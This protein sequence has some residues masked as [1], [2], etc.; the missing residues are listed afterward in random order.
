M[1][2]GVFLLLVGVFCLAAAAALEAQIREIPQR[3]V[4]RSKPPGT[5]D[6]LNED[7]LRWV[8]RQLRLDK[9]Q[10]QQA[11][12]L[13]AVHGAEMKDLEKNATQLLED[14]QKKYMEI[15]AAENDGNVE[16]ANRKREELREL[17]PGVK[18]ESSFFEALEEILTSEQ[19]AKVAKLRR[20]ART[21]KEIALR[22]V[23]VLRA[24]RRASLSMEQLGRLEKI[25]DEFRNQVVGKR[26]ED[27]K[28][29][30]QRVEKLVQDIRAILTPPQAEIYDQ[31]IEELRAAP[32][33]PNLIRLPPA[34]RPAETQP[35]RK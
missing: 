9:L 26:P 18:Q 13:L 20:K 17:G 21:L 19:K 28:E 15:K 35:T 30:A 22:P 5:T 34:S 32:P 27:P 23:H 29:G 6:P 8:C 7:R 2:R 24:A 10:M 14:I 33:A 16:L 31:Q 12:A 1:R 25:L 4:Q 3:A 11:E